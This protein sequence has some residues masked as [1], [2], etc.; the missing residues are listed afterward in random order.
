MK[1]NLVNQLRL[2]DIIDYESAIEALYTPI[3]NFFRVLY[4]LYSAL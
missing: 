3:E 2:I 1:S 4:F